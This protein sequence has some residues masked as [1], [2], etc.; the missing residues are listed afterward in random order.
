M[1][2]PAKTSF[3]FPLLRFWF[4]RILLMWFLIALM[5][6]LTQLAVCVTVRDNEMIGLMQSFIARM[7]SFFKSAIGGEILQGGGVAAFIAIGYQHPMVLLLFMF[8]AVAAP[9]G[10]LAGEVQQGGMELILSRSVTKTQSYLC[11]G[12]LTIAG[13]FALVLAMFLGTVVGVNIFNHDQEVA[14][15][16]FFKLAINGGLLA[17]AVAAISLL[18]SAIFRRRSAAV[19]CAAIFLVIN[20]FCWLFANWWAPIKL[21]GPYTL[22]HYVD[23]PRIF[24]E[25]E[26]PLD[27]MCVLLAIIVI[28]AVAGGIVWRRR[29]LPL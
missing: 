23:G 6:F 26:W 25:G 12:I 24:V 21:L 19:G 20:Y 11:A 14:L 5:I 29:D 7:P 4:R 1:T 9:S 27:D 3:P 15:R 28:A 18:S 8:F 10:L 2:F 16:P 17:A 22:Y 13:M